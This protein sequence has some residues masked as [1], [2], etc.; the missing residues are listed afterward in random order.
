MRSRD[1]AVIEIGKKYIKIATLKPSLKGAFKNLQ[2]FIKPI[3]NASDE[4]IT[5]FIISTFS[6]LRLK[7]RNI[8][9]NIPRNLITARVLSLPSENPKEIGKML[10]LHL[11]RLVPYKKEEIISSYSILYVD[12]VGYTKILLAIIHKDILAR[13]LKILADANLF[14]EKVYMSGFGVWEWILSNYRAQMANDAVYL[15]IDVNSDYTELIGFSKDKLFFSRSIMI[16][17]I[18]LQDSDKAMKFMREIKQALMFL[19]SEYKYK[20]PEKLFIT[21]AINGIKNLQNTLEKELE[22][23]TLFLSLEDWMHKNKTPQASIPK[24]VSAAPLKEFL[25]DNPKRILFYVP[26][27]QARKVLREEVKSLIIA[28]SLCLYVLFIFCSIFLG[29]IYNRQSYLRTLNTYTNVISSDVGDLLSQSKYIKFVKKMLVVR[30]TPLLLFQ[31]LYDTV[32]K[33][34]SIKYINMDNQGQVV[35]RGESGHLSDVFSFIGLLDAHEY[36]NDVET[37]YTRKRKG[38]DGEFTNFELSLLFNPSLSEE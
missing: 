16:G 7:P 30:R 33:E 2:Y 37:K 6:D 29:R 28:G 26:E 38:R 24:Y 36:F 27:T 10:D 12:E 4:E 1:S 17:A 25:F 5:K 18:D 3:E 19:K 9:L 21:G 14:V 31:E 13:N 22:I 23:P 8:A 11:V 35:L 34:V 15:G 20:K 32:P